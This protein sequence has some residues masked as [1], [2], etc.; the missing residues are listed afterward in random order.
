MLHGHFDITHNGEVWCTFE[1]YYV[2]NSSIV[3]IHKVKFSYILETR[4]TNVVR[5]IKKNQVE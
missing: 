5:R 2:L 3:S 4:Q 1:A